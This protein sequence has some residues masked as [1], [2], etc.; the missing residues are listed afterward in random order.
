MNVNQYKLQDFIKD[1]NKTFEELVKIPEDQE[2]VNVLKIKHDE[3]FCGF[4]TARMNIELTRIQKQQKKQEMIKEKLIGVVSK[5]INID[6]EASENNIEDANPIE[7]IKCYLHQLDGVTS[8]RLFCGC[9]LGNLLENAS[10][11]VRKHTKML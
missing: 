1:L 4:N 5:P 2:K 11:E 9:Q 7:T 8:M 3:L 10:F 6:E